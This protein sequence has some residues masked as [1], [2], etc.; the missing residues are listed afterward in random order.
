MTQTISTTAYAKFMVWTFKKSNFN[1][2]SVF[3]IPPKIYQQKSDFDSNR[4]RAD[5]WLLREG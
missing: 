4:K 2:K 3:L 5:K 1:S